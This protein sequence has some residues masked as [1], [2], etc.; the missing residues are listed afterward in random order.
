M[1]FVYVQYG[2]SGCMASL[3]TYI[4]VVVVI[5]ICFF[6]SSLMFFFRVFDWCITI[7][8]ID[9]HI[10]NSKRENFNVINKTVLPHCNV[11]ISINKW[12]GYDKINGITN[13]G[14]E[15][16]KRD[17]YSVRLS[18]RSKT[19]SFNKISWK[20]L[21]SSSYYRC[22]NAAAADAVVVVII[23]VWKQKHPVEG[24]N[25]LRKNW[26]EIRTFLVPIRISLPH[27]HLT[28]R[29]I[30]NKNSYLK[31]EEWLLK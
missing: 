7:R 11:F 21:N 8:C 27:F 5:V 10:N 25:D 30:V 1:V 3:C 23:C 20:L 22:L 16:M 17:E 4:A 18:S 31:M 6:S 9:F 26:M 24:P 2:G 12:I 19:Y 15:K 14:M 28:F 13:N 29:H